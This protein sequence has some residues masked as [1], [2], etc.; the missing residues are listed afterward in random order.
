MM[1]VVVA[2]DVN[3]ETPAGKRRLRL[4]AKTCAKYGQRVHNSVF[5]C[6]VNPSDY[7][8]LIHDL[9]KIMN[10]EMDSLR[11]YRLGS[12]Y[13]GKIEHYGMQRHLPVDEVMMI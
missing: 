10:Q 1:M 3:T 6:S 13:S 7:L 4:V 9:L 11:L 12:K 8:I 5:E 2:Y